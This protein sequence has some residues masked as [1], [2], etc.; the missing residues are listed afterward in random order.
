[1]LINSCSIC[2]CDIFY[3]HEFIVHRAALD[4]DEGDLTVYNIKNHG[5]KLITCR[6]CNAEYSASNFREINF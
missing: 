5:I 2:G 1:M 3:I 6:N 4:K